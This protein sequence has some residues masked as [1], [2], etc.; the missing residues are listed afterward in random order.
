MNP[1]IITFTAVLLTVLT[2]QTLSAQ[3]I[4]KLHDFSY[5]SDYGMHLFRK[6]D[7]TYLVAGWITDRFTN[8]PFLVTMDVSADGMLV[9][10]KRQISYTNGA[11]YWSD[12][13]QAAKLATGGYIL[14]MTLQYRNNSISGLVKLQPNGDTAFTRTYTDTNAYWDNIYACAAMPDGGYAIG[15]LRWN[16]LPYYYPG[17]IIRTDSLGDTLWTWAKQKFLSD[18]ASVYTLEPVA[19]GRILVGAGTCHPWVRSGVSIRYCAPWFMLLDS[20]GNTI[21]DTAY[22]SGYVWSGRIHQDLDGGYIHTGMYDSIFTNDPT[23]VINFPSYV[24]S[25]DSN[26]RPRWF[27]EFDTSG[28]YRHID[29]WG[30]QQLKDSNYV[31]YGGATLPR[32]PGPYT[33]GWACKVGRNGGIIWYRTYKTGT[34]SAAESYIMDMAEL[35]GGNLVF[36]GTGITD[37]LPANFPQ[38][39]DIW[40]LGVDSNG[41]EAAG[42]QQTTAVNTAAEKEARIRM[43]PNPAY[44]DITVDAPADGTIVIYDI[45]GAVVAS[46]HLKKGETQ[47]QLPAAMA[48]GTYVCRYVAA[49]ASYDPVM[50]RLVYEPH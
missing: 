19:N 2:C 24:A 12:P 1:R 21:K 48:A 45:K 16:K 15:G 40:V 26:F 28:P 36:V 3:Y 32:Q 10:N 20:L 5:S 38:R 14:G 18:W 33:S 34:V 39:R 30:V 49:L 31:V 50:L 8:Q 35:P 22:T 23:D 37:S 46:Y 6:P 41:C 13:G 17:Y 7:S 47:L 42:C 4:D 29:I 25:L 9:S 11:P 43:W 44:A 27:L